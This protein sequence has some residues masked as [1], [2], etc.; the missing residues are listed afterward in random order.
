MDIFTLQSVFVETGGFK[1]DLIQ[2]VTRMINHG[3]CHHLEERTNIGAETGWSRGSATFDSGQCGHCLR[4]SV[5]LS[6]TCG[7]VV[8][9]FH[10]SQGAAVTCKGSDFS[11]T[12]R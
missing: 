9:G 1:C 3:E 8:V 12:A 10:P 6:P 7:G 2:Q 4:L 11:R 5:S